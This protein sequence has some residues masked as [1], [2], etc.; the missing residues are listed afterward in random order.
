MLYFILHLSL[1]FCFTI[2]EFY[3]FFVWDLQILLIFFVDFLVLFLFRSARLYLFM[4][5]LSDFQA[6][7]FFWL[8]G[9]DL[10]FYLFLGSIL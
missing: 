10:R 1:H 2:A 6:I 7:F 4:I 5:Y 9:S 3:Y 8:V